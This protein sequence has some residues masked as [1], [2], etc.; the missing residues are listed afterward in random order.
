M[1]ATKTGVDAEITTSV[2]AAAWPNQHVTQLE[3]TRDVYIP[4]AVLTNSMLKVR[5]KT[6]STR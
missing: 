3:G 5:A 4:L 6:S 2:K 1:R